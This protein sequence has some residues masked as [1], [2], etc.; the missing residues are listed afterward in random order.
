MM[1]FLRNNDKNYKICYNKNF[2]PVLTFKHRLHSFINIQKLLSFLGCPYCI[3]FNGT[4]FYKIQ[5]KL[6]AFTE[7]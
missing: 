1:L 3:H 7:K 5:L 2:N 4:L 6:P